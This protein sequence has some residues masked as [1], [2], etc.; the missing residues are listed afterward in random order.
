MDTEKNNVIDLG[1]YRDK[2]AA[3]HLGFLI[4]AT[5]TYIVRID[6]NGNLDWQTSQEYDLAVESN[7]N[8]NLPKNNSILNDAALL[9]A[10]PCEGLSP[11]NRRQFKRL[12]GEA[13]R[14]SF[15]LDY[16]SAKKMIVAA[17]KFAR[18]RSEEVSR[19]WYLSASAYT[20]IPFL[21]VGSLVWLFRT[22]TGE[23]L[24][25]DG[26]WMILTACAGALGALFSVITRTGRL[27]FDSSAGW[28]LHLL[29]GASRIVAGSISGVL[30][31][32][33][34]R[35]EMVLSAIAHGSELHKIMLLGAIAGGA[36]ERLATSI[37]SKFDA[38]HV[39]VSSKNE[40]S[41]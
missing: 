10:T 1:D 5:S 9:E 29:E 18:V 22:Y 15:E 20:A 13:L 37:I 8:Y 21:L 38:G 31:S 11:E 25:I 3:H 17:E 26:L 14:C 39:D 28:H 2:W 40:L 41:T 24:G 33:A 6:E 34:I 23:I 32:L 19:R 36:G 27:K 4:I 7:P 30:V 16:A 35:S 12:I